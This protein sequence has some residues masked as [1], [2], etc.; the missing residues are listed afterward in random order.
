MTKSPH[1]S[2][3]PVNARALIE[4]V[5][6]AAVALLAAILIRMFLLQLFYIPSASMV[7][8]L[9]IDDKIAVNKMAYKF[10]D[11]ERGDIVVFEKPDVIEDP[12]IKFLIKRVI[13]LPGDR[14]K[15]ICANDET[16]CKVDIYINDK[17]LNEPYLVDDLVY[18][19]FDEIVVPANSILVMGDNRD[20][21]EDG[22]DE[23]FGPTPQDK[24]IGRALFRVWP[25]RDF[26][27]L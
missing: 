2:T 25:L 18:A 4:V 20:D 16:T 1:S 19:P 17:K 5:V 24:V 7:P 26:G 3:S 27:F 11:I 15:G 21:S 8:Y 12:N 22:R 10:H 13:G 6:I 14:V 23:R 9:N